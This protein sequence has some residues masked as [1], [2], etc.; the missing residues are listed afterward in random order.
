[1][2]SEIASRREVSDGDDLRNLVVDLWRFKW[3]VVISTLLGAAVFGGIAALTTPVYRGTTIMVPAYN[4]RGSLSGAIGAAAGQLG[5]LASLVGLGVNSQDAATEE[6]L[7][8]FRSR[9]FIERFIQDHELLPLLFPK[10]WDAQART[11]RSGKEPSMAKGAKE[12]SDRIAH[13][14]EEKKTGLVTLYVDWTDRELAAAWANELVSRLN[15]EMRGR[16]IDQATASLEFLD[17]ELA[18]TTTFETRQAINRLIES[19]IKQRMLSSVSREYAFR[20]V[21]PA[22]PADRTDRVRPKPAILVIIGLL[23]GFIVAFAT[24][25]VRASV[26]RT[27]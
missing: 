5:G 15:E 24:I 23:L 16:A 13:I 6:A 25:F 17:K 26:R 3:Y 19:Q 2:S 10:R 7:A 11:W 21:D 1:M 9:R 14:D 8:V 27:A 4:E 18:T 22:L 12:F 20:V